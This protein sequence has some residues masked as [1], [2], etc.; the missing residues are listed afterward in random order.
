MAALILAS[1][2]LHP[3]RPSP[4]VC[5]ALSR[6]TCGTSAARCT[7][8]CCL[9]TC[10]SR[11]AC[12]LRSFGCESSGKRFYASERRKVGGRRPLHALQH[13]LYRRSKSSAVG[14][15]FGERSSCSLERSSTSLEGA[16]SSSAADTQMYVLPWNE[17]S[18]VTINQVRCRLHVGEM[19]G[20]R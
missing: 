19:G 10:E 6:R 16:S 1:L 5:A 9:A 17:R 11:A 12:A 18:R 3:L 4:F 20:R 14:S 7:A 8:C 2:S 13:H 15:L